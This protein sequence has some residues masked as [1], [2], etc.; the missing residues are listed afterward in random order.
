MGA[1]FIERDVFGIAVG[2]LEVILV[3]V[4]VITRSLL[5][6]VM[7]ASKRLNERYR[8]KKGYTQYHQQK[9]GAT[10]PDLQL[11]NHVL[12][13]TYMSTLFK[14]RMQPQ[15]GGQ[16]QTPQAATACQLPPWGQAPRQKGSIPTELEDLW[17]ALWPSRRVELLRRSP[18][19]ASPM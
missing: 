1:F 8:N 6:T 15:W 11:Y 3:G 18:F 14:L 16:K 13:P 4:N 12:F 17:L 5:P 7:W 19:A 9:W 2:L 10:N